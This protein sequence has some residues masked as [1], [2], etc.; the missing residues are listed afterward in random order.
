MAGRAP[1]FELI[2]IGPFRLVVNFDRWKG[3]HLDTATDRERSR[4]ATA[5]M[6][7]ENPDQFNAVFVSNVL[8]AGDGSRSGLFECFCVLVVGSRYVRW[9]GRSDL[10]LDDDFQP[11]LSVSRPFQVWSPRLKADSKRL[12]RW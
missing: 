3:A 1:R 10:L 2:R 7:M 5:P 8:R 9:K 4:R 11:H 12:E 6:E